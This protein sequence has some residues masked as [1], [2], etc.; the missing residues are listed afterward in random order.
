MRLREGQEVIQGHT[1]GRA[2][3]RAGLVTPTLRSLSV[4]KGL[5]TQQ[6]SLLGRQVNACSH[7]SPQPG[8]EVLGSRDLA[9][10]SAVAGTLQG[11]VE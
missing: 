8:E 5:V 1:A 9:A 7:L 6:E 10:P 2:D 3:C 11:F 4:V